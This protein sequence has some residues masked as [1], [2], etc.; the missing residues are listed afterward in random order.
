MA[1]TVTS[2]DGTVIAYDKQG[3]GPAVVLVDGAFGNRGFGNNEIA[4]ALAEDFTVYTYDRRGRNESG[5]TAPYAV[6]R[7]IED[8]AAVV[9]AAG[10]SASLWGI[11]SGA[12]LVLEA[13]AAGIDGVERIALYE[14][15]FIVDDSRTPVPADFEANVARALAEDR[16]GEAV[17]LFMRDAVQVPRL[18]VALMRFMPMWKKL[19][20]VAHTLPYDFAIVGPN[21]T[22]RPYDAGRWASVT[23]PTLV[24][25]GGKSPDWMRNAASSLA[26]VLPNAR[27]T[28]LEGQTHMVKAKA[29][30]PVLTEFFTEQPAP[31]RAAA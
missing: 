15:P 12:A 28:T 25:D 26:D 8:V 18:V 5:D 27:H 16:R 17:R 7:E 19:K 4:D 3:A 2:A 9:D 14:P 21:Q 24:A 10:G 23:V 29:L 30:V 13:A 1:S 11:S 6:Q 22:G 20:A 31:V